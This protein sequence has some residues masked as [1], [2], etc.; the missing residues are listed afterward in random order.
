MSNF[1]IARLD[2]ELFKS[3]SL[4]DAERKKYCCTRCRTFQKSVTFGKWWLYSGI[5]E[6]FDSRY[7]FEN[8]GKWF[9][10]RRHAF[11]FWML[12]GRS[13]VVL[14]KWWL[15]SG[16]VEI[17]DSRYRFE[18]RGKWFFYTVVILHF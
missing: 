6:I 8:R 1:H 17:F 18:N 10:Y 11:H 4:L 3:F 16:I 9:L 13:N 2:V 14:G 15:Y 7:R 5:V 12:N